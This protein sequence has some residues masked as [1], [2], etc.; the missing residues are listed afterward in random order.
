MIAA[1]AELVK[2]AR[3]VMTDAVEGPGLAYWAEARNIRRDPDGNITAFQVRDA[4]KEDDRV[5]D[6]WTNINTKRVLVGRML[7]LTGEVPVRRDLAA[8]FV[9]NDW[10]YDSEGVD[11]LIQALAFGKLVFG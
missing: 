4:G 10:D 9:G 7:L 3:H 11:V 8:Q 6:E 5:S 2:M 1:R